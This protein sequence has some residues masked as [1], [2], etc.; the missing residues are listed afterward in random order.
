MAE[1]DLQRLFFG[2]WPDAAARQRLVALADA[3]DI[4]G[5]QRVHPEDLHL[6][7]QFLGTV[8][9]ARR[10]AVLAAADGVEGAPFEL[11]LACTGYWPR[12]RIAWC[13]PIEI[14]TALTALVTRLGAQLAPIGYAPEARPY[15][16]HLTLARHARAAPAE[17]LPAP[18]A[19]PVVSFALAESLS[20]A[21]P[22]RYRILRRWPLVPQG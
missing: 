3:L 11:Q 19:W 5:G 4:P 21:A 12:P 20:G 6:T 16:P 1:G 2:L 7:L 15:R 17:A 10:P 18:I 14:P 22:P 8:P 9:V 13:A